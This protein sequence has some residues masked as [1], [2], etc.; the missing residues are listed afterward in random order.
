[1]AKSVKQT[2]AHAVGVIF[3]KLGAQFLAYKKCNSAQ[4]CKFKKKLSKPWQT[5]RPW[6]TLYKTQVVLSTVDF[7]QKLFILLHCKS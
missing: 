7:A 5:L 1:M 6:Q 3:S 4:D 2:L